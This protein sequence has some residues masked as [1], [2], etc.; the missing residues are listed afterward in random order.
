MSAAAVVDDDPATRQ[1]SAH[2]TVL[3]GEKDA[4][5]TSGFPALL[6]DGTFLRPCNGGRVLQAA[7]D[8]E[9]V[10]ILA[11]SPQI[12]GLGKQPKN[13]GE[14]HLTPF[15]E[16]FFLAMRCPDQN[17]I[18]VS[19]DGQN[20]AP[21]VELRWDGDTVVP[22]LATQ[23]RWVR[24]QGRLYLVYTRVDPTSQGIF[25]HRAPLWMSE[26]DPTTLRLKKSTEVIAVPISPGRDDLGNFG[27]TFV[28]DQLSLITTAEFGRTPTGNSRV[29]LT[30]VIAREKKSAK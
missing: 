25:R 27:T 12:E 18:A 23:M 17:R 29:Y 22:S 24:Q 6:A 13:T 11:R 4:N 14:D 28:N 3:E 15:G 26:F 20:F 16:R 10:T 1:W 30:R 19:A 8:G 9:K 21:A 7:F 5:T 2:D